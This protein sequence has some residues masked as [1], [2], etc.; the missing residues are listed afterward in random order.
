MHAS[1]RQGMHLLMHVACQFDARLRK[2][3]NQPVGTGVFLSFDNGLWHGRG[4]I[5]QEERRFSALEPDENL[6]VSPK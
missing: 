3:P 6:G 5:H 1:D 4:L 2:N